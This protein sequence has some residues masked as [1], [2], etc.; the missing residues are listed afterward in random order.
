MLEIKSSTNVQAT[1]HADRSAQKL[2]AYKPLKMIII[3]VK[4]LICLF[5]AAE[6][7]RVRNAPCTTPFISSTLD[8]SRCSSQTCSNDDTSPSSESALLR[9]Q[10][11]PNLLTLLL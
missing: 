5:S 4:P 2:S 7:G 3:V 9:Q 11:E 10:I 8:S 1:A 6:Q